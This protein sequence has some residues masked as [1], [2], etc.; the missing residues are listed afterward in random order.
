MSQSNET[1][2]SESS[3]APKARSDKYTKLGRQLAEQFGAMGMSLML[4]QPLDGQTIL[5]HAESLSDQLIGVARQNEQ[6]YIFLK[7]LV[8]GGLYAGLAM[9]CSVIVI[10]LLKNHGVNIPEKIMNLRKN[11]NAKNEQPDSIAA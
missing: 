10:A 2:T 5:E 11:R 1:G 3:T 8:G 6:F 9:E 4:F 7:N